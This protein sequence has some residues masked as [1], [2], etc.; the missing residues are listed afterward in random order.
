MQKRISKPPRP[1]RRA[2]TLIV[3]TLWA[4][5][6]ANTAASRSIEDTLAERLQPCISCHGEQGRAGP[7]GYYP[8]LAGKPAGYLHQQLLNFAQGRRHYS[9]MTRLI[10]PLTPAYLREMADY[11]AALEVP[12]PPPLASSQTAAQQARGR[13]LAL[14]G[15]PARQLPAC[16]SCHGLRLTG[17]Q[18][19]VPGL[20]G[21][22]QDYLNAQL[23]AW[24]NG[25]R[26]ALAPDCMAVVVRRLAPGDIAAVAGWLASQPV[27][28]D[29]RAPQRTG[30]PPPPADLHCGSALPWQGARP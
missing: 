26:Q 3:G 25:Q 7:D 16:A 6:S 19:H 9:L 18:P 21:L 2:L 30:L 29:S 11:F 14:Q 22:P 20:L 8:R 5:L 13:T 15:D 1:S 23:G 27:P 12:Y 4:V 24:Q 28:P 10:D 17:L